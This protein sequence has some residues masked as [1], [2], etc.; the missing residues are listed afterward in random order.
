MLIRRGKRAYPVPEWVQVTTPVQLLYHLNRGEVVAWRFEGGEAFLRSVPCEG[1]CVILQP[2]FGE[3]EEFCIE[4]ARKVATMFEELRK[5]GVSFWVSPGAKLFTRGISWWERLLA[6][7][8]Q[9]L[10]R[11][12]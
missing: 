12:S 4:D 2:R 5:R 8:W 10:Y 6:K 3:G 7:L 9:L 1:Y 11:T